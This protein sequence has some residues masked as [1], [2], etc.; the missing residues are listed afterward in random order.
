MMGALKEW[1]EGFVGAGGAFISSLCCVLPVAIV[2]LGLGSGAFMATTM[3]YTAIFIPLGVLSVSAGFY[4][5]V[6]ER[7]RCASEGCR[8][9]GR[10]GRLALLSASAV[11]VGV[12]LFLSFFPG[13]S[14]DLLTWATTW[15]GQSPPQTMDM[16]MGSTR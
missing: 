2:L 9:P 16:P 12:A 10:G 3:K 14:Y 7:R 15:R 4:L 8:M 6:R 5:H 11:V 1:L 13:L